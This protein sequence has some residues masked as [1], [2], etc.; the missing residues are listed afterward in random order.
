MAWVYGRK[1]VMSM[2]ASADVLVVS[3]MQLLCNR[4]GSCHW[5]VVASASTVVVWAMQ[6]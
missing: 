1:H 3:L 4:D 6:H 2:L 5:M